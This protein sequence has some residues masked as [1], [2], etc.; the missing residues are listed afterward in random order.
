MSRGT[1][2]RYSSWW[3]SGADPQAGSRWSARNARKRARTN[4]GDA[5]EDR[6][7]MFMER[8]LD[9]VGLATTHSVPI[10][11][12]DVKCESRAVSL[13]YSAP[14]GAHGD[15]SDSPGGSD[16]SHEHVHGSVLATAADQRHDGRV[17]V[18]TGSAPGT[19]RTVHMNTECHRYPR[20]NTRCLTAATAPDP[21]PVGTGSGFPVGPSA[22]RPIRPLQP[23][24]S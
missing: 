11:T 16:Q 9:G 13:E 22:G 7:M 23:G 5:G 18:N 12:H 10:G 14:S 20:T 1:A 3:I 15:T 4:D 24:G 21:D 2:V 8:S 6:R 17:V 19:S